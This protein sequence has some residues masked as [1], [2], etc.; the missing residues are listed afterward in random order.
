LRGRALAKTTLTEY[1]NNLH[2]IKTLL[3]SYSMIKCLLKKN[4]R[5]KL[6]FCI[7]HS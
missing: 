7:L 5:I 1:Q 4:K 3:W 6:L 2:F